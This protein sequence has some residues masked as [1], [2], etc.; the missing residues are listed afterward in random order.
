MKNMYFIIL[1]IASQISY[2]QKEIEQIA[3]DYF[4]EN[5]I[6]T[7]YP[8]LGKIK[9]SGYTQT[10]TSGLSGGGECFTDYEFDFIHK[11]GFKPDDKIIQIENDSQKFIDLKPKRERKQKVKIFVYQGL[12]LKDGYFVAIKTED[13]EGGYLYYLFFDNSHNYIKH[14][15]EGFITCR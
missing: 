15:N 2:S 9:F 10:D 4:I 8:K 1:F 3:F 13:A 7:N 6:T 12:K 14:C 5:I 11:N